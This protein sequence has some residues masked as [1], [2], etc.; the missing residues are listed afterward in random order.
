MCCLIDQ[1]RLVLQVSMFV[2]LESARRYFSQNATVVF[3]MLS[4]SSAVVILKHR[5]KQLSSPDLH[6]T[7]GKIPVSCCIPLGK[8][9]SNLGCFVA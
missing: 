7:Q 1:D 3:N 9:H 5:V 4:C 8:D 2:F 6:P